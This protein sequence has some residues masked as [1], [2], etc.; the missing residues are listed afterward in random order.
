MNKEKFS[1]NYFKLLNFRGEKYSELNLWKEIC[2]IVNHF[3][4]QP[5]FKNILIQF[6]KIT[7]QEL[8]KLGLFN[9]LNKLE[10]RK[11]NILLKSKKFEQLNCIIL[12]IKKYL[13]TKK[14][15]QLLL[16]LYVIE[17]ETYVEERKLIKAK[18][19]L[20]KAIRIF[21]RMKGFFFY[22]LTFHFNFNKIKRI[23]VWKKT[24]QI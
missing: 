15:D 4:N 12:K 20:K 8:K 14:N 17:V 19:I 24:L 16:D 23:F 3:E 10:F 13:Y 7:Y 11:A 18:N 21:E 5:K 9:L 1:E 2:F 22:F 6:Y